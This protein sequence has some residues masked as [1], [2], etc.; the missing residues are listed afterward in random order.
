VTCYNC[1]EPGHISTQCDKPK[2]NKDA[3]PAKGRVFTLMGEENSDS[4]QQ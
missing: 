2:K 3:A 1:N 4:Y